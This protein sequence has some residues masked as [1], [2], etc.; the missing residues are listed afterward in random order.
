MRFYFR[1]TNCL[2][3]LLAGLTAFSIS[4]PLFA[5]RSRY[6][7]EDESTT[8]M[9]QLRD[10]LEHVR[11]EVNNHETE[12]RTFDEKFKSLE[13]ALEALRDQIQDTSK[14][15]K[16]SLRGNSSTLENKIS[17]LDTTNKGIIADMK[18]FKLH[19]NESTATLAQY[20]QKINELEGQIERQNQS[21]DHLQ[22]ALHTLMEALQIKDSQAVSGT[23]KVYR[24][25]NGD[26]LEKIAKKHQVTLKAL[27]ELNKLT[28]DK[29]IIGQ[30]L[31]IP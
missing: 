31:Q 10:S 9:R 3:V 11:H 26:S 17:G 20:V 25:A 29:I 22:S 18:Q 14:A 4:T 27:K 28:N 21:I 8:V 1:M 30:I 5:V 13:S 23:G 15:H 19:A 24:V 7:Y 6:S 12:I 2:T 16:E